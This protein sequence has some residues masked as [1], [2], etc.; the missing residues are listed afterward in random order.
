LAVNPYVVFESIRYLRNRGELPPLGSNLDD[1]EDVVFHYDRNYIKAVDKGLLKIMS[2]MGISTLMSY[3]GAQI[4]EVIGISSKVIDQYFTGTTSPMEG[5]DED[6]IMEEALMRHRFA[7]E[8]S[9]DDL[10]QLQWGGEHRWRP[11]G[12]THLFNP[13]TISLL[14]QSTRTGNFRLFKEY[15]KH[16]ND[17]SHFLATLRGM[18]RFRK[19]NPP[20]KLNE[21][22]STDNIVKRF[23]TG[24]MSLGSISPEVHEALAIAMNQLGGKSNTG[25]GGED[26][27]SFTPNGSGHN[28]RSAIKQVASGRFGVTTHYLVNADELQIKV[29]QGA[30]PGEGGQLPGH[31]VSEYI[32]RLRHS[33]PGVTLISP[34]PHHDIYSIEDL[35][36]LIFDL[37]NCN[38]EAKIC[39]KLVSEVGVG[40]VAAGV[41]KA[42]AEVVIIAGHDGGTGASPISSIKHA[43]SPWELGLAETHQTLVMNGLRSRIRVQVDG[44]LKT[45]RDVMIAAFLGAEEFGFATTAL[46]TQGCIMMRKCHLDTCPV[47]IATQ[48]EQ[49]R[50]HFTGKPEYLVN[51]MTF[52][53]MEIREFMA[54]LGFRSMNE[55]IGQTQFL[56][57]D[58]KRRQWKNRNLDFSKVLYKVT[59]PRGEAPYCMQPQDHALSD[60]LDHKLIAAALPA[61]ERKES[62]EAAFEI[63]NSDRTTG[64]MLAGRIA[65][66][67]GEAGLPDDCIRFHF[68]GVAGQSFGAFLSPGMTFTLYGEANDYLGKG[69]SGGTIVV[70]PLLGSTL[71]TEEN[72]IAGNTLLYGATSGKCFISGRVGERFAVRNSGGIAVTEGVGDHCCEYMTGGIVVVLGQTGRNFAAGMSGGI[73]YVMDQ[74]RLFSRRCNHGMVD[75]ENLT[76]ADLIELRELIKEHHCRTDSALALNIIESWAEQSHSFIKIMPREYRKVMMQL[77][78]EQEKAAQEVCDG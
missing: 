13:E 35:A 61:L 27:V 37:K 48:N 66:L 16:V 42:H 68:T 46:V 3:R 53:A 47:G 17:Q 29:A 21:V 25:V 67:H 59:A 7:Y 73:A 24:A 75:I 49:L 45:G 50:K 56:E 57:V 34:P 33:V 77:Q 76:D 8:T 38:P 6:I 9:R 2:K 52:L 4:F 64:T 78:R 51:F 69:M 18:L 10:R 74:D 23:C 72:W 31:K 65:K 41:A 62:V 12:E 58:E 71:K 15:T 19:L 26:S 44:Q 60:I 22:E 1:F 40:T 14:Q 32:A 20:V 54:E 39:V 70:R 55:L 43:G 5:I 11:V 30:K 63:K 28:R 36:Q